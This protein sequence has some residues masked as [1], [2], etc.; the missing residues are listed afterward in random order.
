MTLNVND[1][2]GFKVSIF[3]Q[4]FHLQ[5]TRR[6]QTGTG[7]R[8]ASTEASNTTSRRRVL[9][10]ETK[11]LKQKHVQSQLASDERWEEVAYFTY[12]MTIFILREIII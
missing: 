1:I 2:A 5:L 12:A 6:V 11:L 4:P 10:R 7:T 8:R 9:S 3:L